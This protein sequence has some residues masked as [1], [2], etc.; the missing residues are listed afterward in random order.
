MTD[1]AS[2]YPY[3]F[4]KF[5]RINLPGVSD[6][7]I[8]TSVLVLGQDANDKGWAPVVVSETLNGRRYARFTW[9]HPECLEYLE[10]GND[11]SVV[12]GHTDRR[13]RHMA[14]HDIGGWDP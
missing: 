13:G 1:R 11:G 9:M 8:G 5:Q 12:I 10:T 14:S 2:Y 6:V 3:K 4:A 7:P